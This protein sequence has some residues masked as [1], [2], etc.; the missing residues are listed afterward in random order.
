MSS[1][2]SPIASF[3]FCQCATIASRSSA[4]SA[5]SASIAASRCAD[6]SSVSFAERGLLDLE[7]ADASLDDVDLERHRVDLDAQARRGLV[8]EVDRLV[9]QLTAGDVAV[10][11][12]RGRDE[13][14]VLDAHTVVDLV[15][16]LEPAQD[17]DRVLDRRLA[18][19]HLLEPPLERGV[20][21]DVL[22]VLV[23]RGRTDHAQLAARQHR[24]DHVAGVDRAFR[25]ARA[26][27]RVQL[28]D[29]GDD[30]ALGVDDLLEHGLE[31]VLELAAVLR[32]GDHRADVERDEPL[33]AQ[34]LGH[35]ALDDAARE[36]L[37][38][39]GLADARL[40]DEHGVVLRAARQH[41]DDA[42]DLLVASDDGVELALARLLGEVAAVLL[43][44]LVLLL[45]VVARDAVTAAHVGERVEHG[46]VG[47]AQPAEEVADPTGDL[48]H[49][50]QHVLGGEVVVAEVLALRVGRLE[51]LVRGG[52][53][54][55]LLRGLAVGLREPGELGRRPGR[56]AVL[57]ETPRR[58]IVGMT[59][60][61]GWPRR[62]ASRC[63]GV[64][65]EW[66]RSRASDW[67]A[68][69]ASPVLRVNVLGSSAMRPVPHRVRKRS[70]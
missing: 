22:A 69:M 46:V 30:L 17:R 68:A 32:A 51:H 24:L 40:T 44:R 5:S 48:A 64:T 6:A 63:S 28:V 20:L 50:E 10:R 13:R 53:E 33:V 19:E 25:A 45:G 57:V 52:R 39:R 47:D 66:L 65:C 11:Q 14:R 8:D 18:H 2:I 21:L 37:R 62:A 59:T 36:A 3:S 61:S 15:A 41:L 49:R 67:A 23:E 60:L 55:G 7:L 4:S 16:L 35:V 26:D 43:E 31:P 9:G 58:S 54:L 56:A 70:T 1:R 34:A 42:P 12:H 27:D 29:E 38:D